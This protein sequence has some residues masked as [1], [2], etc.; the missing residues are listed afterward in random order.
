MLAE[1]QILQERYRIIRELGHGGM[2]A[3]YEAEDGKCFNKAV[4]LKEILSDLDNKK[5]RELF[6]RAFEKEARLLT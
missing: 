3:V 6:R 5:Q 4:A 1:N 2:G